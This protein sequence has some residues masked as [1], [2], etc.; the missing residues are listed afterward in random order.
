MRITRLWY[1][2][3]SFGKRTH[4]LLSFFMCTVWYRLI[5]F[6]SFD[7][8]QAKMG[9]H[10]CSPSPMEVSPVSERDV[11][12]PV[13][14]EPAACSSLFHGPV[15]VLFLLGHRGCL[16]VYSCSTCVSIWKEETSQRNISQESQNT[17]Y[18]IG[19]EI[20]V[21]LS[22]R[23]RERLREEGRGKPA[24]TIRST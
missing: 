18:R 14:T 20:H 5:H 17:S 19:S 23:I 2:F 16:R 13:H 1:I 15:S 8:R 11:P 10:F 4:G 6:V 12:G 3:G 9:D 22:H 24:S 7:V 21:S